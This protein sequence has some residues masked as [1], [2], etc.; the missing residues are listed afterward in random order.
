MFN[1][2]VSVERDLDNSCESRCYLFCILIVRDRTC[3]GGVDSVITS[4]FLVEDCGKSLFSLTQ[5]C[6]VARFE[7]ATITI[8]GGHST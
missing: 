7:P 6:A 2:F 1:E 4:F 3:N 8:C 5:P